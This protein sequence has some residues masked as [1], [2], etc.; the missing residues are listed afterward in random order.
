[1]SLWNTTALSKYQGPPIVV[2]LRKSLH[3]PESRNGATGMTLKICAPCTN[4]K[5]TEGDNQD[6]WI[7]DEWNSFNQFWANRSYFSGH[8]LWGQLIASIAVA[9]P[10]TG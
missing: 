4:N 9:I 10:F 8:I 6:H 5:C 2:R 1:M 3:W 7:G